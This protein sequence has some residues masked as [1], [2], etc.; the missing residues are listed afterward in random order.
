MGVP[1]AVFL[2]S[3]HML[4][5]LLVCGSQF[6]NKAVDALYCTK[7]KVVTKIQHLLAIFPSL[8][9]VNVSLFIDLLSLN[10]C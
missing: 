3:F 10:L 8:E 9:A 6:R 7:Q 1:E 4:P 2:T 5:V